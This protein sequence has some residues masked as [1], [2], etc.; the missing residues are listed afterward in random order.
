[1]FTHEKEEE[2]E[3]EIEAEEEI[4]EHNKYWENKEITSLQKAMRSLHTR[5]PL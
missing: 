3:V 5:Q 1:M 2:M 4:E